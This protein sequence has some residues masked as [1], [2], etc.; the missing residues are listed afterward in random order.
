MVEVDR[1]GIDGV[2][3]KGPVGTAI[4]SCEDVGVVPSIK[5][6]DGIARA[7]GPAQKLH[8]HS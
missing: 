4:V 7:L 1:G 2:G 5:E 3:T 8:R 6:E